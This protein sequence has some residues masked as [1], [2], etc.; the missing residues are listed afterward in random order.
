MTTDSIW[1]KPEYQVHC[2]N[3]WSGRLS[4]DA[5]GITICMYAYSHCSFIQDEIHARVCDLHYHRLR[6]YMPGHAEIAAILRA[7][8]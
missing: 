7:I 2:N 5:L 3:G 8:D 4:A 1:C 6:A